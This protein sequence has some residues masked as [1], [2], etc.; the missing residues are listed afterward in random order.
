MSSKKK[1]TTMHLDP[2]NLF[3]CLP[4]NIQELGTVSPKRSLQRF[5]QISSTR[6]NLEPTGPSIGPCPL[7]IQSQQNFRRFC[8]N[9]WIDMLQI[10]RFV[11]NVDALDAHVLFPSWQPLDIHGF[12]PEWGHRLWHRHTSEPS[13]HHTEHTRNV[14]KHPEWAEELVPP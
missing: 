12:V 6:I 1:K 9:E 10:D 7:T 5:S 4:K 2:T 14:S 8:L 11:N 3:M 13:P